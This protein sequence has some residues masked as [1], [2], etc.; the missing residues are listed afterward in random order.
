MDYDYVS[1]KFGCERNC[2]FLS[3]N[4]DCSEEIAEMNDTCYVKKVWL[5]NL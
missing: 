2:I 3:K 4:S 1:I 5:S